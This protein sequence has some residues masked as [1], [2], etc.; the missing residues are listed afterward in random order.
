[1]P[2]VWCD[3]RQVILSLQ[4][5]MPSFWEACQLPSAFWSFTLRVG[6]SDRSLISGDTA[7]THATCLKERKKRKKERKREREKERE[8]EKRKEGRKRREE[9]RRE[10]KRREEKRRE[11]KRREE[12]RREKRLIL[13]GIILILILKGSLSF[14]F[15]LHIKL[16]PLFISAFFG[17]SLP[18]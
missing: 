14:I 11:E 4:A 6:R 9:K 10:E 15:N 3:P 5:S 12:K 13:M 16:V 17:N 7:S 8:R 18:S 1:M 2:P